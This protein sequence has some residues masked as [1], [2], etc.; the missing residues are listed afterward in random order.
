[1][2]HQIADDGDSASSATHKI[3]VDPNNN[4]PYDAMLYCREP[5]D[6]VDKFF[7]LEV[8]NHTIVFFRFTWLHFYCCM[9]TWSHH[10]HSVKVYGVEYDFEAQE[11]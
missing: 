1:M 6:N 10:G 9:Y 4:I 11:R 3:L 8:S 2:A 5:H 7:H